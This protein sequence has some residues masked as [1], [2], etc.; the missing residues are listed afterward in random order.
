MF[1]KNTLLSHSQVDPQKCLVSHF[2]SPLNSLFRALGSVADVPTSKHMGADI[3]DPKAGP[4]FRQPFSLPASAQT[5][6]RTAFRAAGAS[7]TNFP[8]APKFAGKPFLQE[9]EGV[10][11]QAP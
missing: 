8:A 6:A 5:L 2:E 4:I 10:P 11:E 7:G 9:G 3:H 1:D